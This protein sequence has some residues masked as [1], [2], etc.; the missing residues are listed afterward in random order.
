[1]DFTHLFIEEKY[2]KTIGWTLTH[3][4]WQ[5]LL[6]SLL[7]WFTL[8]IV[9][10][11][12]SNLR[13][14]TALFALILICSVSSWTFI[15]HLQQYDKNQSAISSS[16]K[17]DF[18]ETD[19]INSTHT[20]H[21][22]SAL[23]SQV[24]GD[25]LPSQ[26]EQ[27]LP[28]L[29][30]LWILGALFYLFRLIGSI[31]DLKQLHKKHHEPVSQLLLKKVNNLTASLGIFRKVKV[32]KSPF[33]H[34]PITYGLFKPIILLP[35][36]LA[37]SI[38]PAQLEAIIAHEMAH[39]KRYDY[40]VNLFQSTLE[41]LFFFHPCFWWINAVIHEERENATDD[42]ALS[43]G[44]R[45]Q[46][47]AYGLAEVA[48]HSSYRTPEMAL[49]ASTDRNLTLQRIKRILGRSTPPLKLSPLITITMILTLIISTI[50]LVGAQGP[51][52]NHNQ[53]P[54]LLTH[55]NSQNI[56]WRETIPSKPHHVVMASAEQDTIPSV[57]ST[58]GPHLTDMPSLELT[59]APQM[60]FNFDFPSLKDFP[61][62]PPVNIENFSLPNLEIKI[63]ADSIEKIASELEKLKGDNSPKAKARVETLKSALAKLEQ[64][65]E[66]FSRAFEGKMENWQEKH[67][68]AMKKFETEMKV[69]G[70]KMKE[71]EKTWEAAIAPK[72]KE[73]ENK[74]KVWEKENAPRIKEFE[75]KMKIWEEKNREKVES[76]N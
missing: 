61:P 59:P 34:V 56:A 74:M 10:K 50:L 45:P 58:K 36:S 46:D 13:Y 70:E 66:V 1:M 29:V 11:Q 9:P 3:S 6:I 39:I 48:N 71:H 2:L 23:G 21:K 40:L 37:L 16:L 65:M 5:I 24:F 4:V 72:M 8:K 57:K 20:L 27:H 12:A 19:K 55:I 26:L 31:N 14:G 63:Q 47:L 64:N 42:L 17:F 28:Y 32:L 60:D 73:F 44:I 30:N 51:D 35:T 33:V 41:V 53:E 52:S 43:I 69:W 7:L 62:V 49:A 54:L 38:Q 68:E 76:M 75:E 18:P 22:G 67:G 25:Y 15:H